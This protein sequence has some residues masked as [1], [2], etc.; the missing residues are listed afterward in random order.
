MSC[1]KVDDGEGGGL[2][3]LK[4]RHTL[5]LDTYNGPLPVLIVGTGSQVAAAYS[6]TSKCL[7][8][9]LTSS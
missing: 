8:C 1:N 3:T 2:A 7:L 4:D 6:R 9:V 5:E